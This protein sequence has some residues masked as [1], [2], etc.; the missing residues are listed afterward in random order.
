MAIMKFNV[1]VKAAIIQNDKLLVVKHRTKGFWDVPG[2]RI[3]TEESV[4]QTLMREL[5][6]EL[7]SHSNASIGDIVCAYRVPGSVIDDETG[8]LLLVYRVELTL[9][10]DIALSDEHSEVKWMTFD[11]A[12]QYGSHIVKET[13]KALTA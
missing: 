2:G 13:V 6:E 4:Q 12:N 9:G 11:E 10:D 5:N 1:G 3:D 8:L 7:P